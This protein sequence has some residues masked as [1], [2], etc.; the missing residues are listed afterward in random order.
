MCIRVF[1][2]NLI[3]IIKNI[4]P[5]LFLTKEKQIAKILI[6][7]ALKLST[8][9]SCTGGLLSSRLTDISGSSAYTFQNFVTYANKAK[10]KLL[11]VKQETIDKYG[12]VSEQVALEMAQGLLNNYDCTLAISTTGIAGPLGATETKPVGL[13]CIG[14]SDGNQTKTVSYYANPHLIRPI[15]KYAFTIK[16]LNF[17]SDFLNENYN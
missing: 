7:N 13:V 6:K 9:E 10:V 14:I 3:F 2:V 15:M 11:G 8:A 5:I 17:L 4:I 12:V 1:F 16:T